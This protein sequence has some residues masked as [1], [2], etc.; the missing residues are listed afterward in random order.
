MTPEQEV[1]AMGASMVAGTGEKRGEGQDEAATAI[2]SNVRTHAVWDERLCSI[3]NIP[4][5]FSSP[6][7]PSLY[8]PSLTA[9]LRAWV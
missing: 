2:A 3:P 9:Q 4:S 6:S 7:S 8:I 1:L 5:S